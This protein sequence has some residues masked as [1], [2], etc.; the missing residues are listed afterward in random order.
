MLHFEETLG[1]EEIQLCFRKSSRVTEEK[2]KGGRE[3]RR[4]EK[5]RREVPMETNDN[6]DSMDG[7]STHS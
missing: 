5:R 1:F 4:G 6:V 2:K 3:E 7:K